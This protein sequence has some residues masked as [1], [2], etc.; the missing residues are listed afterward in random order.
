[1]S[2][3]VGWMVLIAA[4]MLAQNLGLGS[5][6][7]TSSRTAAP[8]SLSRGSW[9]PCSPSAYRLRPLDRL[10]LVLQNHNHRR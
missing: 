3:G 5:S 4:E 6:S 9:S 10:M 2:L 8:D 7:G 1:M